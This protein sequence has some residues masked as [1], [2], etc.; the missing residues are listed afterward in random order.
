VDYSG[1]DLT[2]HAAAAPAWNLGVE[3]RPFDSGAREALEKRIV[4]VGRYVA[5]ERLQRAGRLSTPLSE[6]DRRLA[7]AWLPGETIDMER[8]EH[9]VRHGRLPDAQEDGQ[10]SAASA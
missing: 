4:N 9:L 8:L 10:A 1:E 7:A 2:R 5:I 3:P 6:T